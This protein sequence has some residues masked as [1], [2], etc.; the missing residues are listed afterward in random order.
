MPNKKIFRIKFEILVSGAA[1]RPKSRQHRNVALK[2][3]QYKET[4]FS[5]ICE[6]VM[7]CLYLSLKTY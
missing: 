5:C 2:A 6:K 3:R 7:Q 4:N 1:N